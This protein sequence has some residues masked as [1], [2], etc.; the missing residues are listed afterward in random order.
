MK[1]DDGT[2]P[3]GFLVA[4][5]GAEDKKFELKVL[6][7]ICDLPEGGTKTVEVVP[8]ASSEPKESSE[9]YIAAFG[10]IGVPNVRVMDIRSRADAAKQE[11]VDRVRASDVV[12]FTGGDQLKITSVLGGSPVLKAIKTHYLNGGV[13]AGT[14]AG[15]AAMSGTM[16][17][18]GEAEK[19]MR[20]GNVMMTPGLGLI[21]S[22][23]IDTH[24]IQRGRVS[25]LLEVVTS[26]P[27]YIGLG[28]GEDTG[29]VIRHGHLVEVMGTGVVVVVDG[30]RLKYTNIYDVDIGKPIAVEHMILHTLVAGHGYDLREQRYL[31]PDANGNGND[32]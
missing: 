32:A 22:A 12:F 13:V 18:E 6:R 10:R 7:E 15:V 17:F 30:H 20:K 25:R 29:I 2:E 27:G 19:S 9:D 14:S 26:N 5:G 21:T 3:R 4:V 28:L 11:L 31:P 8:L 24:F 23:V 1:R 16:I